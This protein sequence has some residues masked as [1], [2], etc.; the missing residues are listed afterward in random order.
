MTTIEGLI[1]DVA[2][3]LSAEQPLRRVQNEV[4]YNKIQAIVDSIQEVLGDSDDD[5]D[6]DEDDNEAS[7]SE[8]VAVLT[9]LGD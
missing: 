8:A 9:A 4:A 6:E 1:R 3:D 5:E 7:L 2:T